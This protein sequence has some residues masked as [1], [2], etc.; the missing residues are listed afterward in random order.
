MKNTSKSGVLLVILAAVLWSTSAPLVR[1]LNVDSFTVVALRAFFAF[2]VLLPFLRVSKI[3]WNKDLGCF[4][5]CYA[6]LGIA[7]IVGLNNTS[8]PIAIGMQFTACIWLFLLSK[9]GRSAFR[10]RNIWPLLILIVGV[11]ISMLSR[12]DDVTLLGNLVALSTSFSFAGVT[13]F[14]KKISTT[15][16]AGLSCI[17]NLFVALLVFA[18]IQQP[19]YSL[20][21][22]I[23]WVE[24][25]ILLFLGAFQIGTAFACY[26]AG[27]LYVEA[28][29]AS[30][31]APLE[32][33]LAPIWVALFLSQFPDIIGLVGFIFVIVGVLGE[34]V[35]STRRVEQTV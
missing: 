28:K 24:W 11:G 2:V 5:S 18:F 17:S 15:N 34:A 33:I 21:S 1:W 8:T 13:Y 29:T 32:M 16:P 10:L 9:P 4:L 35:L 23:S 3:V 7:I 12:A 6:A 30:M 31:F 20:L 19:S 26:Y 27:L 22:S 25:G 14:A